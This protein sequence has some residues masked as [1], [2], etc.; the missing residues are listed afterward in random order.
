MKTNSNVYYS[1]ER[2]EITCSYCGVPTEVL[3]YDRVGCPDC[4]RLT[5]R[6]EVYAIYYA[7]LRLRLKMELEA[8]ELEQGLAKIRAKVVAQAEKEAKAK[9]KAAKKAQQDL[10]QGLLRIRKELRVPR[11]VRIAKMVLSYIG[12]N[13]S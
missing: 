12:A 3:G 8:Q 10:E 9:A 2:D 13:L 6:E 1:V 4:G 7:T 11:Y 5:G